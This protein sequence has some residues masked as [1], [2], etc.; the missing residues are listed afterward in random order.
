MEAAIVQSL[1]GILGGTIAAL[2]AGQRKRRPKSPR[3][4][5]AGAKRNPSSATQTRAMTRPR[6]LK[7]TSPRRRKNTRPRSPS[8]VS[9]PQ[10][11]ASSS[12]LSASFKAISTCPSCGLEAPE[13]L[14]AEHFSGSPSHREGKK[15]REG[16]DDAG[17][18][19][20]C[21]RDTDDDDPRRPLRNLL[22]MLVPPRA[23]GHRHLDKR[24]N[25]ISRIVHEL[26]PI[27]KRLIEPL[28]TLAPTTGKME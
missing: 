28:T 8:S 20:T 17:P 5:R 12:S 27:R 4:V 22:Q 15:I 21:K 13:A 14:M 25:P 2:L 3:I 1:M 26:D 6:R 16:A 7:A 19:I 24:E 23:F 18:E 11:E 10:V 9:L